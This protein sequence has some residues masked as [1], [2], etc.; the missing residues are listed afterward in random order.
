VP[1]V[2]HDLYNISTTYRFT[3]PSGSATTIGAMNDE[4]YLTEFGRTTPIA[5]ILPFRFRP[6]LA[7]SSD[8][9]LLSPN[10]SRTSDTQQVWFKHVHRPITIERSTP[11]PAESESATS[12]D[13]T[14]AGLE[15]WSPAS[16]RPLPAYPVDGNPMSAKC[17]IS[18]AP[19][20]PDMAMPVWLVLGEPG[21]NE[22]LET[23]IRNT[24]PSFCDA[25]QVQGGISVTVEPVSGTT[26]ESRMSATRYVM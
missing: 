20:Y 23:P 18:L 10:A 14:F 16:P 26:V 19:R 15:R 17:V 1:P 13:N 21:L 3:D 5:G 6:S 4:L 2:I 24:C 25:N 9:A 7:W 8:D 11:T 22:A 12:Q